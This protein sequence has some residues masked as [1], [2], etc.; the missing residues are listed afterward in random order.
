MAHSNYKIEVL[1][2]L[3]LILVKG[4]HSQPT[5]VITPRGYNA[6]L[7]PE[8]SFTFQCD[9]TGANG[10]QWLVDGL[11]VSRQDIRN[12]GISEGSVITVDEVS[13]S[14]RSTITIVRNV[15]NN[16]NIIL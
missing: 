3:L 1:L 14:L 8:D 9:V 12:R 16:T 10:V 5:A 4:K 6:S 11:L 2:L 13:G 15:N 7:D